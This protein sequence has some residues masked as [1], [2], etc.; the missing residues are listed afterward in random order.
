ME[1]E[2]K[3]TKEY[4]VGD[5]STSMPEEVQLKMLHSVAGLENAKL[6]RPG[7]AIEYDVIEPWQLKLNLE[8]KIVKNLFTA[9]QMNGT[10]GY[11]E[12]AGQG[13]MAGINAALRAEGKDPFILRRDEAYIGVLIDDLVTKGTNEPYR[14]LTSRAEYRLILRHDNADLRLTDYGY[15]LGLINDKRYDAFKEKRQTIEM[16]LKRLSRKM[17]TPKMA[18]PFLKAHDLKPLKDGILADHF[19]RRPEVH[20]SDIIDMVGE[21]DYPVDRRVAEQVEIATKYDGYIKKE[22]MRI[23][24]LK[25][26]ESKKIPERID[27][28]KVDSLATEAVQKLSKINPQTIAQASRISGV[29]PADIGILSVYI[30]QGKIA[31]LPEAK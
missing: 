12:A 2:G 3:D 10:S 30:E 18:L 21:A 29:N 6:M 9:G 28:T 22:K 13:I 25:K 4:Y 15:K 27:Y 8:T 24:R 1:P 7:Y 14:L 26:M 5:F 11:E 17:I 19:L 23:E 20:Y 16:E 31:K